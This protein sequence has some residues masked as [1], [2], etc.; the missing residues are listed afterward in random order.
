MAVSTAIPG[1]RAKHR[2]ALVGDNAFQG[3][4][5]LDWANGQVIALTGSSQQS[6]VFD[7]V[8]DRIV[9]VAVGGASTVGGGF[10]TVGPAATATA[11]ATA[12]GS[13]WIAQAANPQPIYVPAGMVIAGI[14]GQT[15]GTLSMIP[16]L[17]SGS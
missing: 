13:E 7:S 9:M 6:T 1:P 4:V 3:A 5:A 16:A 8:L 2:A 15:G 10:I 11:S 12:A 14:Q 17:A